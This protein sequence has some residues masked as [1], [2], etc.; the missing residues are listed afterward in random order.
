MTAGGK[1]VAPALL[2]DRLRAHP[3]ISQAMAVGDAQPFI[4]ALITIDPEA[5]PGWK[6]RN[7][8]DAG[9]SVADLADDPDLRR[10]DRAGGQGGQPGGVQGR[11]DPQVPHPAGRLHRGHRRADPDAEGQAQGRGREV[12]RRHRRAVLEG[13]R[14]RAVGPGVRP[15]VRHCQLST[16][17]RRPAAP[18]AAARSGSASRSPTAAAMAPTSQPSTTRPVSPSSTV[19]GAPPDR[20]ATTGTPRRR[21]LQVDDA[22]PLDVQAARRGS[23]TAS[24]TRRPCAWCAGNS[25][26]GTP[27]VNTTCSATPKRV[28]QP[29][30]RRSGTGRRRR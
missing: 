2:E 16:T 18:I 28:R 21:R 15:G 22:Q 24:R 7:G 5:F 8:K 13:H 17:H 4:A 25:S 27:S 10:R 1:N 12:R 29:A 26:P 23:G 20:P 6:E 3:L 14:L 11:A 30:Q 9:A 19:S